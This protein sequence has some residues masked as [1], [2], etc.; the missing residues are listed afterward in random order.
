[1]SDEEGL[2]PKLIFRMHLITRKSSDDAHAFMM[3]KTKMLMHVTAG[4]DHNR[5]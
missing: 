3:M 1:M 5:R 4:D 2:S